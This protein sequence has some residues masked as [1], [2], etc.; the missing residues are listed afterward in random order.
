MI[1]VYDIPLVAYYYSTDWLV[2]G[3]HIQTLSS[4]PKFSLLYYADSPAM[5]YSLYGIFILVMVFFTIGCKTKYLK[6]LPFIFLLSLHERNPLL[7]NGGDHLLRAFSFYL[8]ISPCGEALS[9]DSLSAK[10]K[11]KISGWSVIL[12]KLRLAGTYFFSSIAKLQSTSWIDG[13]AVNFILRNNIFN[14]VNM[15]WITV[16][17]LMVLFLTWFTLFSS[18]HSPF[19]YGL[20]STENP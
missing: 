6:F 8:M 10:I 20:K 2:P 19:W 11:K 5:V 3:E 16:V 13:T 12:I 18:F 17:P 9:I 14:R 4:H 1:L 15:D 7:L